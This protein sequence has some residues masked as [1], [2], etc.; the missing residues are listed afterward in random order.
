MNVSSHVTRGGTV[1]VAV[2]GEIDMATVAALDDTLQD[3]V[4]RGD[5]AEVVVDFA[6][7][8]FCD[9]S[10]LAALDRAYAAARERAARLRIVHPQPQVRLLFEI[11][12]MLDILAGP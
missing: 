11:T 3:A 1:H 8:T 4:A 5:T 7:V 10:G 6:E 9:S 2:S 12:G